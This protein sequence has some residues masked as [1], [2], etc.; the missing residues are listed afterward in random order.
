MSKILI[1]EDEPDMRALL[2]DLLVEAGHDV[3]EVENGEEALRMLQ[4]DLPDLVLLDVLMPEING[5]QVLKRLRSNP[6]TAVLPVI[7]LT[8]FSLS[9]EQ[10][11]VAG[12]PN[13]YHFTKPWRRG[14]VESAVN[15]ALGQTSSKHQS[16]EHQ[17]GEHQNGP[18][19]P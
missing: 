12:A 15:S 18:E 10:A 7:L 2:S 5:L 13:T 16:G 6:A 1:A 8:A 17:S 9:D 4:G 14:M 11:G 3:A 19:A